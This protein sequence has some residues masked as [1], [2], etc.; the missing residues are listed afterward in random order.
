[1]LVCDVSAIDRLI[2]MYGENLSVSYKDKR[3]DL[4]DLRDEFVDNNIECSL[5]NYTA[6]SLGVSNKNGIVIISIDTNQS[7]DRDDVIGL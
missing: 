6:S 2:D 7:N 1:M 4:Y 3:F 5:D